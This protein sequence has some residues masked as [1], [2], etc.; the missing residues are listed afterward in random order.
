[1]GEKTNT[2]SPAASLLLTYKFS[3]TISR[4]GIMALP[5]VAT[6]PPQQVMALLTALHGSPN[7]PVLSQLQQACSISE[8][9]T[10]R[11]TTAMAPSMI[12]SMVSSTTSSKPAASAAVAE[13]QEATTTAG[14]LSKKRRLVPSGAV[15][16]CIR[17]PLECG[18]GSLNLYRCLASST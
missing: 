3:D 2:D 15:Y 8:K 18:S 1:M 11:A 12:S 5:L 6:N 17:W 10:I 9:E 16:V 14:T 7:K 4:K 13:Y